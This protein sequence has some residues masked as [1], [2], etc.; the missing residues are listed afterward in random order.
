M[1]LVFSQLLKSVFEE[2]TEMMATN[3]FGQK[4]M[5]KTVEIKNG[6]CK[7]EA[8]LKLEATSK[9][10]MTEGYQKLEDRSQSLEVKAQNLRCSAK[11]LFTS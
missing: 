10:P 9:T 2:D 11:T 5:I 3:G 4:C 1:K 7:L 6:S 8:K